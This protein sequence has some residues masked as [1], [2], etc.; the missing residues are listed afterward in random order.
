[1][2]HWHLSDSQSFPIALEKYPETTGKMVN[3]G[4]YGRNQIYTLLDVAEIV[5]YAK[6]NGCKF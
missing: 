2:F 4:S 1:M 6:E 3:Y 5:N